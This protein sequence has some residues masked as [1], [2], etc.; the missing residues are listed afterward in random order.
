M[1]NVIMQRVGSPSISSDYYQ[2]TA[3]TGTNKTTG[4]ELYVA[5]GVAI[6]VV[7]GKTLIPIVDYSEV[8]GTVTFNMPIDDRMDIAVFR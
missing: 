7:E 4:R 1:T 6:V 3:C 2:G 8:G 5:D